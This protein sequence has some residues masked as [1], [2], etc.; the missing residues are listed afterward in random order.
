VPVRVT[1]FA[2][3]FFWAS[4]A[5]AHL[6]NLSYSEIV[7]RGNEVDYKLRFAAHLIP[8]TGDAMAEKLTRRDVVTREGDM[9]EWLSRTIRVEVGGAPCKG[10]LVDS[11]GP[12]LNDDL[13]VVL[14]YVCPAASDVL[15]VEFRA[16][17][18]MMPDFQ[19]IVSVRHRAGSAA[20]VFTPESRVLAIG[21]A[22]GAGSMG[23]ADGAGASGASGE[24]ET[25]AKAGG[26]YR[27]FVLGI[28]HILTG[29]DHL[30]FL[31][32]LL[33]P[34]GS[35]GRLA[36]IVTAFTVAHSITLALAA[37]EIVTL[38]AAPVEAAIAASVVLAAFSG[39]RAKPGAGRDHRALLTFVFG[40]VHGFGFASILRSS[41]L[42]ADA[43]TLPL[44]AFNLGVEAG[45]LGVVLVALPILHTLSRFSF[46]PSVVRGLGWLIAAA[47]T[48]WL[49][50][51]LTAWL[52]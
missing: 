29:Y 42:P 36:G 16:F 3:A 46:G 31:L 6:G 49:A 48:F 1:L 24:A 19:N 13:T 23:L 39:L 22:G 43:V 51:R 38:P 28:E 17:D 14:H 40:L 12:D 26:F 2:L 27:F 21:S 33:L 18:E 44:L 34:G 52:G 15:R 8:G 41:G 4:F 7:V 47:G 30:L 50:D 45:Q 5:S 35:I 32:A 11:M 9:A 37:L 10:Q 25:S 20:Y